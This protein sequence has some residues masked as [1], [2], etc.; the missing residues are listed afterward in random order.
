MELSVIDEL[1]QIA[2]V[3]A[4]HGNMDGLEVSE[5]LPKI[6]SLKIF[7]WKIGVMH[8]AEQFNGSGKMVEI[9]KENGFNVLVYGHTHSSKIKWEEENPLHQSWKPN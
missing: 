7:D 8:D 5:A 3:L 9:A 4:V 2:P 6:N 1:E